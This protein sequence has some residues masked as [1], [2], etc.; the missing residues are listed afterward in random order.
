MVTQQAYPRRKSSPH[1]SS[2]SDSPVECSKPTFVQSTL[3]ELGYLR[4]KETDRYEQE[5]GTAF[6]SLVLIPVCTIESLPFA[7]LQSEILQSFC[8]IG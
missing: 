5:L 7:K 1:V 2:C 3:S 4:S 8:F 6:A